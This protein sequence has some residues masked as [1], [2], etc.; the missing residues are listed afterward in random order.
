MADGQAIINEVL[1]LIINDP[2]LRKRL[3]VENEKGEKPDKS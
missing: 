2:E 1:R 3:G